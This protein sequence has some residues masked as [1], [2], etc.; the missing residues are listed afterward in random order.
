MTERA[1][2]MSDKPQNPIE[3]FRLKAAEAP[4]RASAAN[5]TR[6]IG[7]LAR[8][9]D[10]TD[11]S[12]D[13]LDEGFLGEWVAHQ[14]Y[15]GYYAKTV[16][17]NVSKIA[18]LYNKAVADNLASPNDAFPAVVAKING[19]GSRFDGLSHSD[20]FQ[21]LRTIFRA[22]YSSNVSLQLA[23]DIVLFG[24]FNGG[25]T[26]SQLASFKKDD[27][28]YSNVHIVK[29]VEKYSR[30]KNKYLFPLHQGRVTPRQLLLAVTLLADS[31][32]KTVGIKLP[33]VADTV[34]ADLWCDIAMSCGI[35]AADAAG[36]L[37]ENTPANAL[38]FCV[39]PSQLSP[40][41]IS[42]IRSSVTEALADNP[43]HWYAMHLRRNTDFKELTD[44]LKEKKIALDE[45]FYPM[46]EIF[47][48]V[49]KKKVFESRPV[50]S[51]LVFYRTRVTYLNRLFHEIGDLAWGYRYLREVN[52]PYA[53]I[54]DSE[55]R[56][57]QRAIGTLSPATQLLADEEVKFEKGDYLVLL[58]GPMNGRHGVFVAEKKEKG[59]TSGRVVFRI[60]LAG[61]KNA[62]WE[63]NWDPRLVKKITETQFLE[64]DRQFQDNLSAANDE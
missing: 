22:D 1:D 54:S 57:Y 26:L 18:A 25:M 51:W 59:A 7:S 15:E 33:R 48:K 62:N 27:Y 5:M 47:H 23:R 46:E 17:Y 13:S 34:L 16:A 40:D 29:I 28:K 43:V 32:L 10:G 2:V 50:I 53:V 63:V 61:G 58:G 20:T 35:S 45:I 6:A 41:R 30:P 52:S 19:V 3:Y 12:F 64:L 42:E 4:S 55:I 14:F 36:C 24:I 8:F 44:R 60:N 37:S 56:D 39:T 11:F 38:T 9:A 49:G 31:L 21:R